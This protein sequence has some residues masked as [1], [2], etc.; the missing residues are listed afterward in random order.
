MKKII[1]LLAFLPGIFHAQ[2]LSWGVGANYGLAGVTNDMDNYSVDKNQLYSIRPYLNY[3]IYKNLRV[4]LELPLLFSNT[5]FT[6]LDP[7]LTRY[8]YPNDYW[9][10]Y[11]DYCYVTTNWQRNKIFFSPS[12]LLEYRLGNISLSIGGAFNLLDFGNNSKVIS[13]S[14]EHMYQWPYIS[15][16]TDEQILSSTYLNIY[17]SLPLMSPVFGLSYH[18]KSLEVGYRYAIGK[19]QLTVG[20]DIGRYRYE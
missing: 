13:Q 19:H 1:F 8:N 2:D 14:V 5:Q 3:R 6:T 9:D 15:T 18:M 12:L 17:Q 7:E 4:Q 16:Y 20:Y 11:Y 10:Y